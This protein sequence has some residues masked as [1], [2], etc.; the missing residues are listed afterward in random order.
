MLF[1]RVPHRDADRLGR[2]HFDPPPGSQSTGLRTRHSR[3]PRSFEAN[4]VECTAAAMTPIT[5][6][7]PRCTLH[8]ARAGETTPPPGEACRHPQAGQ[9][10]RQPHPEDRRTQLP[11]RF[12]GRNAERTSALPPLGPES[13]GMED[14]RFV[15]FPKTRGVSPTTPLTRP[16]TAPKSVNSCSRP[17]L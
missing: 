5:S 15:R 16:M 4:S 9:E 1:D 17:G 11:L 10:D 13:N 6:W 14:A 7:I 2:P 8:R 3:M 12:D